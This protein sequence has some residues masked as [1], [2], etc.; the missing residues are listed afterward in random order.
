[1]K[2]EVVLQVAAKTSV[3][4]VRELNED[5]FVVTNNISGTDWFLPAESYTNG[6][7]GTV[8]VVADGM[9]GTNAGEVASKIAVDSVKKYFNA[10]SSSPVKA[11]NA[12]AILR[13]A[14]LFAHRAI[15]GHA[16]THRET[17]GMG[18]TLVI[19]W[20]VGGKAYV[21]WSGDSRCYVWNPA[22]GLRQLSKDHSYVQTLVDE[23]KITEQQAFDHPQNNIVLQSLGDGAFEPEPDIVEMGITKDDLF[24]V[25]SDGLSGMLPDAEMEDILRVTQGDSTVAANLL[26]DRANE[27]GGADNITVILTK[28]LE[29]TMPA[30]DRVE[31][32]DW[33][34]TER[35]Q[36]KKRRGGLLGITG[37]AVIALGLAA[38]SYIHGR[39]IAA[40]PPDRQVHDS[41]AMKP[42]GGDSGATKGRHAGQNGAPDAK[43]PEEDGGGMGS[44]GLGQDGA[45]ARPDSPGV[46]VHGSGA[47]STTKGGHPKDS[48]KH[49]HDAGEVARPGAPPVP[50]EKGRTNGSGQPSNPSKKDSTKS[51][52][53]VNL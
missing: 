53:A 13:D 52:N 5:N 20:I 2:E 51:K 39:T 15:V 12:G 11:G 30:E 27:A 46:G 24:L 21:G 3:G 40:G 35:G 26:V 45:E 37:L 48:V 43:T 33:G 17:E 23:G 38:Y 31:E 28:V 9:G 14:I 50:G 49:G 4:R 29:N 18:T 7:M 6:P 36:K 22:R 47:P 16:T 44:D 41:A 10:L 42:R 19:G 32:K 34:K 8:M 1:M 25:C